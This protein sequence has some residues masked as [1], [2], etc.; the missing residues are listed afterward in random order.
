MKFVDR[1]QETERLTRILKGETPCLVIVRGR[2]RLGKS[3]LIKRVLTE[4]DIYYEADKTD[5][6][7]QRSLLANVASLAFSGLDAAN[8]PS[9]E[10]LFWLLIIGLKRKPQFVWMS[11]RIWQKSAPNCHR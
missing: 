6:S 2:R 7:N 10:A 5:A 9:W 11:F 8:Y 1:K 3:T 4:N